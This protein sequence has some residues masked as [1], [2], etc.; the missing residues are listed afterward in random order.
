MIG[1]IFGTSR[2][3]GQRLSTGQVVAR[4]VTRSV[5][6]KV[7]GQVAADIGKSLGGSMGRLDRSR[8]RTRRPRGHSAPIVRQLRLKPID[9]TERP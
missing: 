6:N 5:T 1:T 3:R 8:Y 7:I 4:E 9:R 2:K